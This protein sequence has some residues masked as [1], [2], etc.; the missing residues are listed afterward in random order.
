MSKIRTVIGKSELTLL[1][2]IIFVF[3]GFFAFTKFVRSSPD[4]SAGVLTEADSARDS[5][6]S[7]IPE[8][9]I[10]A[11]FLEP[12]TAMDEEND[13]GV[14]GL[15]IIPYK[16]TDAIEQT[17]CWDDDNE[18]SEHTM[19]LL[20]S[21]GEEVFTISAK[22]DCATRT[23]DEGDYEMH[24]RHDGKS[25][26]RIAVFIVPEANKSLLTTAS[27]EALQNLTSVLNADKCIGCDLSSVNL[28]GV[29][30]SGVDLSNAILNNAILVDAD[31]SRA[32][33]RGVNLSGADLT[34]AILINADL[35]EA[36]LTLTN[37][38][39]ADK[40]GA[41]FS[42]TQLTGSFMPDD[43]GD[44]SASNVESQ[45]RVHTDVVAT[46]TCTTGAI[47]VP[48]RTL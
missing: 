28:N 34:N 8:G 46:L 37:L 26:Q 13:T 14:I 29:D 6:L 15:D 7:A 11:T 42:E 5:E 38:E 1:L 20:N 36:D 22:G 16:Y 18:S 25:D 40:E 9:G 39:N 32:N 45:T 47:P 17:F 24:I 41:K 31:L 35:T 2:V 48:E 23:I 10:V 4:Q 19:T 33:L 43:S 3:G 27:D 12:P 30:L 44:K 21:D